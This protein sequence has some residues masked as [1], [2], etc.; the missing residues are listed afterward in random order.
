[1][2]ERRSFLA[3]QHFPP[4]VPTVFSDYPSSLVELRWFFLDSYR[5]EEAHCVIISAG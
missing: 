4:L 5:R 2:I 3:V 1:M